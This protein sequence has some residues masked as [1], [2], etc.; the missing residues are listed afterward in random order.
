M[1]DVIK[2]R[3]DVV[4]SVKKHRDRAD[5]MLKQGLISNHNLLRAEVAL[6]R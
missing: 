6:D 1:N 5:K 2:I 3:S 4:E